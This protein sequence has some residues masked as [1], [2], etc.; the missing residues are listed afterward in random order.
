MNEYDFETSAIHAG[1]SANSA[2]S[3]LRPPPSTTGTS[4]KMHAGEVETSADLVS[5][6]LAERYPQWAD[7]P[8]TPV[9]SA[10]TDNALYRLGDDMVVRLPR[11]DW[12]IGQAEKERQWLPRLSPWLPLDIPVQ[13]AVGEPGAG[14]PWPWAVYRWLEGESATFERLADPRKAA[15]DLAR[16]IEA[17]H[18]IDTTGGPLAAE[19]HLR[20]AP[21]AMRDAQTREA[22]A[23]LKEMMDTDMATQ[24]W[25][26]A[27]EAPEWDR[28]PV[29][30][31]GDLLSGNLL[32]E[33]GNLKAVIDFSGLGV[34]DPA[35]DLMIAWGLFS[36][37]SRETFRAALGVDDATW[38]RGR[39]QALS[40]AVIFIPYYLETNPVGVNNA[41][42]AVAEVLRDYS[43]HG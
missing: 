24:V 9:P 31:H 23:A 42:R 29:W 16:F 34:G 15:T 20:G 33:Q 4:R 27:L 1:E 5:R 6:L 30:F 8:I 43:A 17:L 7:L 35:C 10:G 2:V 37:E 19:H 39:G 11:I 13:L 22:L 3:V 36:G 41:W 38:A 12:A 18:R 21:L 26:S 40:Q 25:E 14:Y 28:E 32:I